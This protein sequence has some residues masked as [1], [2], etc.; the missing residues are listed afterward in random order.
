MPTPYR[1]SGAAMLPRRSR[2]VG[3]SS[4]PTVGCASPTYSTEPKRPGSSSAA[5]WLSAAPRSVAPPVRVAPS[6]ANS[7]CWVSGVAATSF[8]PAAFPGPT[9]SACASRSAPSS[10][11]R[12]SGVRRRS[13]DSISVRAIAKWVASVPAE[14]STNSTRSTAARCAEAG[15]GTGRVRISTYSPSLRA[16]RLPGCGGIWCGARYSRAT[17]SGRGGPASSTTRSALGR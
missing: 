11:T 7:A 17:S 2:R 10:T 6:C 12:S 4:S 9:C 3:R 13:T 15:A 8:G 1:R 5:A 16:G 14:T